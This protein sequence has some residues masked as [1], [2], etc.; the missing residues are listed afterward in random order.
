MHPADVPVSKTSQFVVSALPPSA[1][2]ALRILEVGCGT[3]TLAARLAEAGYQVLALDSSPKA[4]RIACAKGVDAR[5]V[6]WPNVSSIERDSEYFD[7]VLFS[8][9]LHHIQ[10]LDRALDQAS[11]LLTPGGIVI[12]E[13]FAFH[14]LDRATATW[15]FGVL[16]LLDASGLFTDSPREFGRHFLQGGG[17]LDL[18]RN[19]QD[20][21]ITPAPEIRAAVAQRFELVSEVAEPY[22]YRYAAAMLRVTRSGAAV[23]TQLYKVEKKMADESLVRLIGRRLVGRKPS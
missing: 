11:R 8:R 3:G 21:E 22:L 16:L 15:F 5:V 18:W 7:A 10:P 6:T 1:A 19:A 14:E 20:H 4:V 13:D 2:R 17:S 12:I 23:A 9:S